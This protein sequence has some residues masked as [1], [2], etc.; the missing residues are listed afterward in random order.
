[1]ACPAVEQRLAFNLRTSIAELRVRSR[2]SIWRIQVPS[3]NKLAVLK[4]WG[5]A[6]TPQQIYP[7]PERLPACT[8]NRC[9]H[10]SST[11][12]E[13]FCCLGNLLSSRTTP[14]IN[15]LSWVAFSYLFGP[16]NALS[17][18]FMVARS[19]ACLKVFCCRRRICHFPYTSLKMQMQHHQLVKIEVDR[20]PSSLCEISA[21]R[22]VF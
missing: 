1:M 21:T 6:T 2:A 11:P 8:S 16:I 19:S 14:S 3:D 17:Q 13:W 22:A 10:K 7:R 12:A 5:R 20:P 15:L 4:A 9:G 18:R